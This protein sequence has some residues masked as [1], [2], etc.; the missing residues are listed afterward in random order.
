MED[1]TSESPVSRRTALTGIGAGGLGLEFAAAIQRAAAQKG[2]LGN[3][4]LAGT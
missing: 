2:S 4:P 1:R 3:Q